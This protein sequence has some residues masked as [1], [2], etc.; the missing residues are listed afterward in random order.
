[1]FVLQTVPL[2]E[3][4]TFRMVGSL[5]INEIT[6]GY[7]VPPHTH[8]Q[9]HCCLHCLM[10]L[11]TI[12]KNRLILTSTFEIRWYFLNKD[13]LVIGFL[14]FF[15]FWH[16]CLADYTK[17]LNF[18]SNIQLCTQ[19]WDGELVSPRSSTNNYKVLVGRVPLTN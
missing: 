5:L 11:L 2:S 17:Q 8:T 18:S 6:Q 13:V 19:N 3:T 15:F 7:D 9:T 10:S 4:S 14:L 12:Q 1:M 16:R